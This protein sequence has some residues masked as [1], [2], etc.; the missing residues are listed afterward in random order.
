MT[1]RGLA[2]VLAICL[3]PLTACAP[4]KKMYTATWFDVFDTV[5]TVQGYAAS[6]Q[7][8]NEQADALHADLLHLHKQLDIYNAYDGATNLYT[9]NRCAADAPFECHAGTPYPWACLGR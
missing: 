7:E 6:E 4:Q 5:T 9:V 8:W 3:L 1:R 2:A